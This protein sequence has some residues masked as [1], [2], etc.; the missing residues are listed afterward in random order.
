VTAPKVSFACKYAFLDGEPYIRVIDVQYGIRLI[1][2]QLPGDR[3]KRALDNLAREFTAP[4]KRE[5][6][7]P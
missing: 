1:A 5:P 6:W 2:L 7:K 3:T 4:R